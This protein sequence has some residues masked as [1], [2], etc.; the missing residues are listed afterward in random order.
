MTTLSEAINSLPNTAEKVLAFLKEQGVRGQRGEVATCPLAVWLASQ[1]GQPVY[2]WPDSAYT[3][4]LKVQ[5]F[6]P[7]TAVNV[8]ETLPDHLVQFVEWFDERL[9]PGGEALLV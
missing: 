4:E 3:T 9:L 2:V 5:Q 7:T 6:G 8:I 1:V